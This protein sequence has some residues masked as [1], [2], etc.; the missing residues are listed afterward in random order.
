MGA[1]K[2]KFTKDWLNEGGKVGKRAESS[3]KVH[4]FEQMRVTKSEDLPELM[5]TAEAAKFL[6]RHPKT[7]EEYRNEGSLQFY[8][9]KGRYFTT[10]EFIAEFLNVEKSKKS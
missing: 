8:K 4:K 7:L 6:R 9:I 2:V 10:P 5:S 1:A 3:R